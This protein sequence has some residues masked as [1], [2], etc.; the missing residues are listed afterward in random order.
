MHILVAGSRSWTDYNKMV[1]VLDDLIREEQLPFAD[2][3]TIVSGG[4]KGADNLAERYA[5]EK[6][7]ELV[8]IRADWDKYGRSAGY[9]RNEEMHKYIEKDNNRFCVCFWDGQSKGTA[10]NFDLVKKHNTPLTIIKQE[11][12]W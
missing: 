6:G 9:R 5:H 11:I 8:V 10:H 12:K 1:K 4:A 7:Y 2:D 3:V